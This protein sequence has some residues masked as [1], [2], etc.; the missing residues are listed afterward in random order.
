MRFCLI[1][2]VHLGANTPYRGQ[3]RKLGECAPAVLEDLIGRFN[4][5]VKPH[6]IVNM[7]DLLE[8]HSYAVDIQRFQSGVRL[9]AKATAPVYHLLGN[10]D[11]E[12]ISEFELCE[13]LGYDKPYYLVDHSDYSLIFIHAFPS[14]KCFFNVSAPQLRWLE[15]E[16]PRLNKPTFV[17]IHPSLADPDLSTSFWFGHEDN[18][19]TGDRQCLVENR[20]AVRAIL[21][22]SRHIKA[23]FNGHIHWNNVTMHGNIPYVSVQAM[24]ENV[25][26]DGQPAYAWTEVQFEDRM[27]KVQVHGS[28]PFSF[29]ARL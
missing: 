29:E 20:L 24:A 18:G 26:N 15:Q 8:D 6:F 19:I 25:H 22:R 9:F 10:H 13:M 28:D 2:D 16:V 21:E 4:L 14:S 1:A 17:F 27:L 23:V 12:Q 7:G 11:L 3:M 5:D